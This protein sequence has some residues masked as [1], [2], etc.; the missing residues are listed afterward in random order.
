MSIQYTFLAIHTRRESTHTNKDKFTLIYFIFEIHVYDDFFRQFSFLDSSHTCIT[1]DP[2]D[3]LS[4]SFTR[5]TLI[6]RKQEH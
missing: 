2:S 3:D 6:E 4:K 5:Y 1:R